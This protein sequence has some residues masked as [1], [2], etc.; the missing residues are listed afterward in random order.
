MPIRT[1]VRCGHTSHLGTRREHPSKNIDVH[2]VGVYATRRWTNQT[3]R[4]NGFC[5]MEFWPMD[6]R[7]VQTFLFCVLEDD[8]DEYMVLRKA[9]PRREQR[10]V[11]SSRQNNSQ[12]GS[13]SPAAEN[14]VVAANV[15]PF[16]V[17]ANTSGE[18]GSCRLLLMVD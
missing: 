17:V 1:L 18:P 15:I 5:A 3:P 9:D 13:V 10:K 16:R 2:L 12:G 4:Q 7:E 14:G 6:A 8:D 11:S